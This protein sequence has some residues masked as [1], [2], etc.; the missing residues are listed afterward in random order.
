M[1]SPVLMLV[2]WGVL[3]FGLA[4]DARACEPCHMPTLPEAWIQADL[5]VIARRAQV[6]GG[7][8]S[9]PIEDAK[10]NQTEI[11]IEKVLKGKLDTRR[12]RVPACYGMCDYGLI[13]E[14]AQ[15]RMIFLQKEAAQGT[16]RTLSLCKAP[17]PLVRDGRVEV[18]GKWRPIEKAISP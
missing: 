9:C 15:P 3:L 13:L 8:I 2:L 10:R 18:G 5:V 6:A 16:Y 7:A 17:E 1:K 14:D 4:R 12:L 11:R